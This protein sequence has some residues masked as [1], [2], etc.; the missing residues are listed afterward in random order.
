M[1]ERNEAAMN[2]PDGTG[3]NPAGTGS[4]GDSAMARGHMGANYTNGTPTEG[5]VSSTVLAMWRWRE[6]QQIEVLLLIRASH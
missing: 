4:V 1:R 5:T 2:F 3:P 6:E